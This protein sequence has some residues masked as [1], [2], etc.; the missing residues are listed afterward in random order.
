MK[1]WTIYKQIYQWILY[2]DYPV[3]GAQRRRAYIIKI[4]VK[5]EILVKFK[6]YQAYISKNVKSNI[7]NI[8]TFIGKTFW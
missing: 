7:T 3:L 5:I 4:L 2:S 8:F 1:W 6:Y